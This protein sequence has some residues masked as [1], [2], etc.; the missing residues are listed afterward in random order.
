MKKLV[1]SFLLLSGLFILS[2][3]EKEQAVAPDAID[4]IVLLDAKGNV[5]QEYQYDRNKE[6]FIGD[7]PTQK[8]GCVT[9]PGVFVNKKPNNDGGYNYVCM[10]DNC[11][12]CYTNCP[13]Q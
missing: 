12:V 3:C 11:S 7:A 2:S 1:F 5:Q 8:S 4:T 10:A 6:V 13:E 9:I